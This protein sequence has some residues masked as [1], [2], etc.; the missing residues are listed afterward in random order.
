MT[1]TY[2]D[3]T[4]DQFAALA[5]SGVKGPVQM[6]N[7]IRFREQA[8][9]ENGPAPRD[10]MSGADA[11]KA[12]GKAS[13]EFFARAGGKIVWSGKPVAG[14]I[15]PPSEHWDT[16]FLAEYPDLSAFLGMVKKDGYQAIVYHR[17]AA[18]A[19]SRLYCFEKSQTPSMLG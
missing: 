12:Y 7:L 11:Y 8:A 5:S 16:G 1:D 15:G 6:L 3:P 2:L 14:V 9:Y 19:D 17:Q 13:A 18:V 10:A 4:R